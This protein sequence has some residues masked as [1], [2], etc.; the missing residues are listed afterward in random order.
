MWPNNPICRSTRTTVRKPRPTPD[1]RFVFHPE[2]DPDYVH[3]DGHEQASFVAKAASLTR[4]NAWWL[5]EAALLSYWGEATAVRR[6]ETAGLRAQFV[7]VEDT[8]AYVA[9]SAEFLLSQLPRHATR[10]HGRHRRR[11]ARDAGALDEWCRSLRVQGRL[12]AHLVAPDEGRRTARDGTHRM[13]RR[14]QPRRSASDALGRPFC[15]HRRHLYARL[16]ACR[17]PTVRRRIRCAFWGP[18]AALR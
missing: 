11:C 3:F 4:A 16:S 17:G 7:E 14:T 2:L 15:R 9:W 13:V 10:Q 1:L 8:Q 12:G 5:A 6:F 18:L